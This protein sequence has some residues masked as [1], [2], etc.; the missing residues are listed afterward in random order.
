MEENELTFQDL[1]KKGKIAHIWEYYKIHIIGAILIIA[2]I[3]TFVFKEPMPQLYCGVGVYGPHIN[4]DTI[5]LMEDNINTGVQVPEGYEVDIVNFYLS[6]DDQIQD[7]DMINKFQTYIMTL[8]LHLLVSDTDR[9]VEFV[10]AD[11]V[12]PLSTYLTQEELDKL[13]EA[14]MLYYAKGVDGVER[15]YGFKINNSRVIKNSKLVLEDYG[16]LYMGVVP[17][18]DNMENTMKVLKEFLK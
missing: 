12:D 15:A 9:F 14:D 4:I 10:D 13:A 1:D 6:G 17:V 5:A 7:A 11:F 8:Q 2:V 16:D 18:E 3:L